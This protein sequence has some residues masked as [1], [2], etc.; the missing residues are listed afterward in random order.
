MLWTGGV[1]KR[2]HR[3]GCYL[4]HLMLYCLMLKSRL[5]YSLP[6]NRLPQGSPVYNGSQCPI[7]SKWSTKT[8][9]H[10]MNADWRRNLP[11]LPLVLTIATSRE[12]LQEL[13]YMSVRKN[14]L[15]THSMITVCTVQNVRKCL[16]KYIHCS[17]GRRIYNKNCC[18]HKKIFHV[19]SL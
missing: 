16:I 13:N 17:T 7:H 5:R 18:N 3:C 6:L 9:E 11:H 2:Q 14:K 8:R 4:K 19:Y 1:I 12:K 15:K 10:F